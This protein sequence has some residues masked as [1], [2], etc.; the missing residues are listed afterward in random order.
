MAVWC[1]MSVWQP[2]F[3]TL[4]LNTYLDCD[5]TAQLDSRAYVHLCQRESVLEIRDCW[6]A[7]A[8]NTIVVT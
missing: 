7:K 2:S 1:H 6:E 3:D 8:K 4:A 5:N